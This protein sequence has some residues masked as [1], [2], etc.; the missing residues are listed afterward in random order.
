MLMSTDNAGALEVAL[1]LPRKVKT[2]LGGSLLQ[3]AMLFL[4]PPPCL[5]TNFV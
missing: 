1:V 3:T 4:P 2:Y 5:P